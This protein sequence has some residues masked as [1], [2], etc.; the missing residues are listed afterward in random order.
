MVV[1]KS[2]LEI[3]LVLPA[4]STFYPS[5]VSRIYFLESVNLGLK[6]RVC[7]LILCVRLQ[8]LLDIRYKFDIKL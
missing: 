4:L 6:F 8:K 1:K 7:H 2:K 3:L 5:L